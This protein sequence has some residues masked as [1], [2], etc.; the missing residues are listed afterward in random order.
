RRDTSVSPFSPAVREGLARS[1]GRHGG[2]YF[3]PPPRGACPIDPP[4]LVWNRSVLVFVQETASPSTPASSGWD[5]DRLRHLIDHAAH[6]LPAQGPI[7]V[8]IHHNTLHAFEELPFDQAVR[9]G[10]EEF[11][12]EPFLTESR[13]R[14]ELD[15]GRIRFDDLRV[16]LREE[17]EER[18]DDSL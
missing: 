1:D 7:D 13:Y 2:C 15:R 18:A 16:V 14:A 3:A 10:G 9:R 17:L 5:L 6:L 4:S 12:C 8:F 11:G